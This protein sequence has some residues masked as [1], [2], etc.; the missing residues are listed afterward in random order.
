MAL[1]VALKYYNSC[2]SFFC[3]SMDFITLLEIRKEHREL[4]EQQI[5]KDGLYFKQEIYVRF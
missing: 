5:S 4:T 3:E 1:P 2:I